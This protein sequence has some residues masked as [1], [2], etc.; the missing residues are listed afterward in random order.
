M[1]QNP[2]YIQITSNSRFSLEAVIAVVAIVIVVG[3]WLAWR[4]ARKQ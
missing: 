3:L 1:I 4:A 2:D